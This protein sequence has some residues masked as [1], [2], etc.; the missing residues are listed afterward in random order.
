MSL[1]YQTFKIINDFAGKNAILD[2]V[3][4]FC[5]EYLPYIIGV[6]ALIFALYW[7]VKSK[8]WKV[9]WQ[10]L[11]AIILSR[12][13]ITEAIRFLWHRPR[14]F[15]SHFVNSLLNHDA[16]GSF[17]SGHTT[18]LFA[19]SSAIYFWNKKIG[20]LFFI[21]SFLACFARIFVGVHYPLDI[22]GGIVIGVFSGWLINKISKKLR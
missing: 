14:P 15:V 7:F 21:L 12:G 2:K 13:I 9:V 11:L 18:L 16:S 10:A 4:V 22:L 20:W 1:D 19:L 17:P 6:G 8:S 5:A 3:G